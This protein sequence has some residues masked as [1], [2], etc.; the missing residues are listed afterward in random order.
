MYFSVLS[1]AQK[2]MPLTPSNKHSLYLQG[3]FK[4]YWGKRDFYTFNR[5]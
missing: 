2:N 5:V 1:D 3:F 4:S